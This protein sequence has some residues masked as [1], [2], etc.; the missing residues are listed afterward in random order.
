LIVLHRRS[1][2]VLFLRNTT[3]DFGKTRTAPAATS[4]EP[5]PADPW[6]TA[7]EPW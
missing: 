3:A 7:I 4:N 5:A 2:V 6:R 1:R